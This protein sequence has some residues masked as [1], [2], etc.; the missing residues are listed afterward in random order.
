MKNISL[1]VC[2]LAVLAMSLSVTAAR[3]DTIKLASDVYPP[4]NDEP[5]S[6]APG[7]AVEMAQRIFEKAGHTVV[8]EV[9]PWARAITETRRGAFSGIIAALPSDAMDFVLP[10][11][12]IGI[13]KYCFYVRRNDPWKYTGIPSLAGKKIGAVN[14]YSYSAQ[15]DPF[16]LENKAVELVSGGDAARKNVKKLVAGHIDTFIENAAVVASLGPQEPGVEKIEEA[17]C[18]M[19]EIGKLYISFGPNDPKSQ[20]YAKILSDGIDEMR[21]SG[22]LKE[23]L[24][25]YGLTDWK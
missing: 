10:G 23:I 22:E 13:A 6:N 2:V 25:K 9:V 16:L 5:G 20:E 15:L 21:S 12:E 11:N 3:A 18:Q 17:G 4:Y 19:D 1:I 14:G 7:Y 8:Y 24:A